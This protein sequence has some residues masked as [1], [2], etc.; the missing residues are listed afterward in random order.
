VC[1]VVVPNPFGPTSSSSSRPTT[2]IIQQAKAK[3]DTTAHHP[4]CPHKKTSC[5]ACGSKFKG[6]VTTAM[7]ERLAAL[8]MDRGAS[9][10]VRHAWARAISALETVRREGG[11]RGESKPRLE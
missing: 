1:V 5:T 3:Q 6:Q 7:I 4:V 9:P 2:H 8:E 11:G 10:D